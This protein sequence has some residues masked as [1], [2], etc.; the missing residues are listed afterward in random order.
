MVGDKEEPQSGGRGKT[1]R[2]STVGDP[3][4]GDKGGTSKGDTQGYPMEGDKGSAMEEHNG[5]PH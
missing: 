1:P 5:G 2:R 4:D 3:T